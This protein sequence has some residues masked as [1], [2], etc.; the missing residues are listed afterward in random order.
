MWLCTLGILGVTRSS[1]ATL[2]RTRTSVQ[3][4]LQRVK[5]VLSPGS[6]IQTPKVISLTEV[7]TSGSRKDNH[8]LTYA[9][10]FGAKDWS[11]HNESDCTTI[12]DQMKFPC[13]VGTGSDEDNFTKL[14]GRSGT[15]IGSTHEKGC[16]SLD[17]ISSISRI[18]NAGTRST[19][20]RRP[21]S[22]DQVV[23]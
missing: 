2:V 13:M 23:P 15:H 7:K 5:V 11:R 19:S 16:K 4:S 20:A 9:W 22:H 10:R 6:C 14:R 1:L 3:C 21:W 12:N 17:Q 18:G 8:L